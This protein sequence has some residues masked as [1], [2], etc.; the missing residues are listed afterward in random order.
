[1]PSAGTKVKNI[2]SIEMEPKP[3]L[4]YRNLCFD[5]RLSGIKNIKMV[6]IDS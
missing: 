2:G 3:N 4:R 6:N 1:M 5:N